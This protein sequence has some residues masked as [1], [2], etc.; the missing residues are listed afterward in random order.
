MRQD[1]LLCSTCDWIRSKTPLV[2]RTA[3]GVHYHHG[4]R[5]TALEYTLGH[6]LNIWQ[7]TADYGYQ[8]T[9]FILNAILK[10]TQII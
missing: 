1:N 10:D 4:L 3:S 8:K 9:V 5:A 2:N 7:T 6:I